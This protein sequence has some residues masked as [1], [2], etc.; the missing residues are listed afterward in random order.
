MQMAAA[1]SR[2]NVLQASPGSE[3]VTKNASNTAMKA[4]LH[5]GHDQVR[6]NK[7]GTRLVVIKR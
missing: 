5:E 1:R 3:G 2:L 4:L 7:R 6:K